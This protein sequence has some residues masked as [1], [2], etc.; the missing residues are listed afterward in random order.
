LEANG[1]KAVVSNRELL[2]NQRCNIEAAGVP[3]KV[4]KNHNCGATIL[5]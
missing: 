5:A 4:L 2:K 3:E 1:A